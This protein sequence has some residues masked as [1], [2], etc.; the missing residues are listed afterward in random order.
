[1]AARE[2]TGGMIATLVAAALFANPCSYSGQAARCGTFAVP[3]TR[4]NPNGRSIVLH[5][6][7]VPP[8]K[9]LEREP[10]FAI[11]GG[12]GQ[13][14][15][16]VYRGGLADDGF[17]RAAHDDRA[18]VL[19]DQRGAGASSPMPCDLTG[20]RATMFTHLFAP[21]IVEGCRRSLAATHDLNAYGT[22]AAVDDL[23]ALRRSLGYSKIVLYGGSYGTDASLVYLRRHGTS[24]A[25]AVL[26]G[27]AP[28]SLLL[29]LPFPSGAQHALN[30]LIAACDTDTACKRNFP[31]F[32]AEFSRMI[33]GSKNGGIAVAGGRISFEVLADAMRHVMYDAY[34]SSYLP[35]IVRRWAAGD[36]VPLAKIVTL[37][38][39]GIGGSL[40]MGMNL[41][42]TCA[43]SM[44]FISPQQ[45][46]LASRDTFMGT[47]RYDAQR[48][49]CNIWNVRPVDATFLSPIRSG[50]PVLMISGTDDP[51]TPP[52]FG[53]RVLA[54]LANGRQILIP[55][56][57]HDTASACTERIESDFLR[58]YDVRTL[59]ATCV[60]RQRRPAFATSFTGLF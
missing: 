33:E 14:A 1:M 11:A 4:T 37:T 28:P 5:F 51:A 24:V 39:Q 8:R 6:V 23:D 12:P 54:G 44:P 49:A 16:D 59:D 57:G 41:S 60:S 21:S 42:I 45:A 19:L 10:V 7:V 52:Q 58:S 32:A 35:L 29:P 26:L 3:E 48:T 9:S 15:I 47:S 22:D 43:E 38:S 40:D 53:A 56:A 20:E 34:T 18:I 25:A 55:G 31:N 46:A 17:L 50:V 30:D 13:S 27:V 36:S 2:K